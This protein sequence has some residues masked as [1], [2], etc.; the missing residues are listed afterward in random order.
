[1]LGRR[2][3]KKEKGEDRYEFVKSLRVN[4]GGIEGPQDRVA[5]IPIPERRLNLKEGKNSSFLANI[6][7]W[8]LEI[9]R[10]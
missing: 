1:M 4:R 5:E 3:G 2:G 9:K 7:T 10:E 8:S 6:L